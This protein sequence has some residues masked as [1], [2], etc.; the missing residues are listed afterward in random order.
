MVTRRRELSKAEIM[1]SFD[2]LPDDSTVEDFI[3]HLAFILGVEQG[4]EDIRAGRT[5]SHEELLERIKSWQ[6]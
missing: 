3:E 2:S 5:V 1:K 4:L 6:S